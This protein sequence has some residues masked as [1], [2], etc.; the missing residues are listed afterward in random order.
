MQKLILTGDINLLGVE[1]P[2]VPFAQVASDLHSADLVF[3]NLECC[4]YES[5]VERYPQEEGFYALP[6]TSAALQLAGVRAVGM[7]N[8]VNYGAAAIRSSIMQLDSLGIAHT[9]AGVDA[10]SA[11]HAAIVAVDGIRYGFLQRTSVYWSRGHEA[12]PD[13]PGVATVRAHT[14]YR[15]RTEDIKTLTRPGAAPEILTW[16]DPAALDLLTEDISRLRREV[17]VVV[18]SHHW[19][20][21]AEVLGYQREI[22][23]AAIDAGADFVF[24]HGPHMLLPM[25]TYR[26]KFIFY[27]VGSF[28]FETGH[29][30]RKH[31]DWLGLMPILEINGGEIVAASFRFVRHNERNETVFRSPID[32]AA[33]L[34]EL[35]EHTRGAR[36]QANADSVRVVPDAT[37]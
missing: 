17:D 25:E 10:N 29:G 37:L 28:S 21:S 4:F 7:A 32:E 24:G 26:D 34:R 16:A 2:N 11:A 5:T 1:D 30:G 27:G 14:A 13:A 31:P 35:S 22:A 18:A 6:A 36:L 8:N 20:L 3:A 12:A 19:G 33:A 23:Q 9:G 15:P